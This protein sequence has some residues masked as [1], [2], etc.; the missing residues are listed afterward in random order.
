[1]V[2]GCSTA[3]LRMGRLDPQYH[4]RCLLAVRLLPSYPN[5]LSFGFLI[6][7]LGLRSALGPHRHWWGFSKIMTLLLLSVVHLWT[8]KWEV[9]L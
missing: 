4:T 2:P 6:C 3:S 9:L 7:K 1:M 8:H 5:I